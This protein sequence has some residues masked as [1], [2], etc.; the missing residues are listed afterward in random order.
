MIVLQ[1][2]AFLLGMSLVLV[3]VASAIRTFVLPRSARDT[4]SRTVFLAIRKIFNLITRRATTYEQRD[5]VMAYYVPVA[6]LA[7]EVYWLFQILLGYL[8]MFWALNSQDWNSAFTDS[9]S[10]LLTLGFAPLN[11]FFS[12]VLAFSEAL[13]GLVMVALLIAYLPTM[14]SAFSRRELAVTLLEVRA[15]SPPSAVEM[16]VRFHTLRR[17]ELLNQVWVDWEVWFAELAESHTTFG[18]LS[19]FRSPEPNHSWI[20]AAGAVLDAASLFNAVVDIKRDPQADLCIRAGYIS[21]RRIADYFKLPFDP[22]P[23][24]DDPISV[25]RGEFDEAVA[26]LAENNVPLKADLNQ[27]WHDFAGWRVNY[28]VPLLRLAAITMAPE[29]PWSSDRSL[30]SLRPASRRWLRAKKVSQTTRAKSQ[31]Y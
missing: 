14:Y 5:Q 30:R 15:G 11:G 17:L 24:P 12:I 28:D 10:S 7:L 21:L 8:C 18:A 9:G 19:F 20:T 27:A 1:I 6:L 26:R 31:S 3:T 22:T 16:L 23:S 4:I 25:T 13:L 29:A 2:G